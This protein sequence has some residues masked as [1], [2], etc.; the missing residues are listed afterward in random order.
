MDTNAIDTALRRLCTEDSESLRIEYEGA[1]E[2]LTSEY[3]D[4]LA[5]VAHKTVMKKGR[6]T[7]TELSSSFKLPVDVRRPVLQASI[8]LGACRYFT[9]G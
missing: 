9:D 2:I 6:V 8:S 5:E 7:M 3:M 1:V 4:S